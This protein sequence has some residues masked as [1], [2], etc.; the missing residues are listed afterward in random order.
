MA[1]ILLVPVFLA[2]A[3][4]LLGAPAGPPVVNE[5]PVRLVAGPDG[6]PAPALEP[7]PAATKPGTTKPGTAKPVPT[8]TKPPAKP[9]PPPS[10][11]PP[12]TAPPA[13]VLPPV[14]IDGDDDSDDVDD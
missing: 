3:G 12:S 1:G 5:Q 8:P 10:T 7:A 13:P 14:V 4:S 6:S 11:V 2:L 9:T